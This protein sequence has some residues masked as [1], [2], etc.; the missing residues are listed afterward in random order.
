MLKLFSTLDEEVEETGT[1]QVDSSVALDRE[2]PWK[3][4]NET[5]QAV[6]DPHNT[7]GS[8][9]NMTFSNF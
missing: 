4:S 9:Q 1:T 8:E 3:R 5:E 2:L 7:A 6:C